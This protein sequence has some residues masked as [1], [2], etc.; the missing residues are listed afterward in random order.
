MSS[1]KATHGHSA[2]FTLFWYGYCG[3]EPDR[4]PREKRCRRLSASWTGA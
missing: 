3:S 1:F 2:I 4:S